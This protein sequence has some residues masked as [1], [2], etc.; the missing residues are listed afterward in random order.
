MRYKVTVV[1]LCV[2][3]T[4]KSATYLIY[5]PNARYLRVLY[6]AL[7]VY[8]VWLLLK[9]LR[10][11]V[12]A[13][14]DGHRR[15]LAPCGEL[16]MFPSTK[17]TTMAS[18]QLEMYSDRSNNTTGSSLILAHRAGHWQRLLGWQLH[19]CRPLPRWW[20]SHGLH[21]MLPFPPFNVYVCIPNWYIPHLHL[22][23]NIV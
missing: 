23:T 22:A 19:T 17:G 3:V 4:T 1:V 20:H 21:S 11:R 18:F 16:F 9:T 12:M 15:F 10:L 14:F 6:S 8:V 7:K 5:T 13:S 2:S